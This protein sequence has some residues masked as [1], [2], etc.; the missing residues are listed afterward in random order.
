MTTQ[1]LNLLHPRGTPTYHRSV[2]SETQAALAP[3]STRTSQENEKPSPRCLTTLISH[4]TSQEYDWYADPEGALAAQNAIPDVDLSILDDKAFNKWDADNDQPASKAQ[5]ADPEAEEEPPKQDPPPAKD[6]GA[7]QGRWNSGVL[8]RSGSRGRGRTSDTGGSGAAT[9][10]T[11]GEGKGAQRRPPMRCRSAAVL[12]PTGA[13]SKAASMMRSVKE[14]LG[15]GRPSS[16]KQ[17][18]SGKERPSTAGG[19]Q[20]GKAPPTRRPSVRFDA[21]KDMAAKGSDKDGAAGKKAGSSVGAAAAAAATTSTA[22]P[23]QR[24]SMDSPFARASGSTGGS[25]PGSATIHKVSAGSAA[26]SPRPGTASGIRRSSSAGSG[27]LAPGDLAFVRSSTSEL[28]QSAVQGS[29]GSFSRSGSRVRRQA[30]QVSLSSASAAAPAWHGRAASPAPAPAPAPAPGMRPMNYERDVWRRVRALQS[31]GVAVLAHGHNQSAGQGQGQGGPGSLSRSGSSVGGVPVSTQQAMGSALARAMAQTAGPQPRP[32]SWPLAGSADSSSAAASAAASTSSALPATVGEAGKLGSAFQFGP[33]QFS[34]GGE[35]SSDYLSMWE[36]VFESAAAS[37]SSNIVQEPAN[38]LLQSA[39]DLAASVLAEQ[40]QQGLRVHSQGQLTGSYGLSPRP[41]SVSSTTSAGGAGGSAR[42]QPPQAQR[43]ATAQAG[44]D[45]SWRRRAS[46][47]LFSMYTQAS[48][49]RPGSSTGVASSATPSQNP[50]PDLLQQRISHGSA[51]GGA[52]PVA[53]APPSP[54]GAG[55]LSVLAAVGSIS[56]TPSGTN[57]VAAGSGAG[58]DA[59]R[60]SSFT[61]ANL[62]PF[63]FYRPGTARSSSRCSMEDARQAANLKGSSTSG[64]ASGGP[65]GSGRRPSGGGVPN[66]AATAAV[67]SALASS[68]YGDFQTLGIGAHIANRRLRIRIP[69]AAGSSDPSGGTPGASPHGA[70]AISPTPPGSEPPSSSGRGRAVASARG[71]P[72]AAQPQS[73]LLKK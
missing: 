53:V 30:S 54:G 48:T 57:L 67:A 27:S 11:E 39:P 23:A 32:G 31:A 64:I 35:D 66:T 7:T 47:S 17:P 14:A 3:P 60:S 65:S 16:G 70:S 1:V 2:R 20:Q 38:A 37:Q 26:A 72:M 46:G 56:R 55:S 5:H 59:A 18:L 25:R 45:A 58:V 73:F 69:G 9:P 68:L 33:H 61:N 50:S 36:D 44:P 49:S 19:Q 40:L 10:G 28:D 42:P 21:A 4:H 63:M 6:A 52:P 12:R 29:G 71:S 13:A 24:S 34:L 43:P 8:V 22:P 41:P 62:S 51:A 15:L